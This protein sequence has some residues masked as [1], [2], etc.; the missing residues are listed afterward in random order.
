M[1]QEIKRR[2]RV[3]E[4]MHDAESEDS[5]GVLAEELEGPGS[6]RGHP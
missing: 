1:G 2:R 5:R 3:G 4:I 6:P